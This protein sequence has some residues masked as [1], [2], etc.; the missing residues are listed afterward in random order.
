MQRLY[1]YTIEFGLIRQAE[2][3]KIFGAGIVSS[4]G[5]ANGIFNAPIK[6]LD[7]Q[8]EK[9]IQTDFYTDAIQDKYFVAHSLEELFQ[10]LDVL[11]TMK[12]A[13]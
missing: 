12:A 10:S 3:L 1:W 5:E 4:Y 7:Y 2:G 9:V 11:K 13:N 8:I 6:T